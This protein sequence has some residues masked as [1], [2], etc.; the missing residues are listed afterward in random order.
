M[1]MTKEAMT[2]Q[3]GVIPSGIVAETEKRIYISN[4]DY[5]VSDEDIQLVFSDVGKLKSYGIHYDRSG[6]SKGTAEVVYFH[7][8]DAL[9]AIKRFNNALLDGKRLKIELVGVQLVAAD[10]VPPSKN[11]ILENPNIGFRSA[12]DREAAE[13]WVRGGCNIGGGCGSGKGRWQGNLNGNKLAAYLDAELD[14]YLAQARR[15]I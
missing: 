2:R 5:G 6:R 4:L 7:H 15:T 8:I 14:E 12:K 10:P 11:G 1:Q 3:Q 9:E 13:G